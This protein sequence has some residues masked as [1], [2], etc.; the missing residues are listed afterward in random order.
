LGTRASRK[1]VDVT[2][3]LTKGTRNPDWTRDELIIALN[4]YLR[5]RISPPGK[6]SKEVL[7]ASD[8]LNRI[9]TKLHGWGGKEKSFRNANGVYMKLMNFRR[10]DPEYTGTG[11]KGLTAGNKD[12]EVVWN[13]FAARPARCREVARAIVLNLD[14]DDAAAPGNGAELDDLLEEAPEGRLLTRVHLRRERNRGLVESKKRLVLK[15][16]GSLTCEVCAFDFKTEYGELGD[17][18]IECHHTKPLETLQPG[19]KT[20]VRDLALVCSNC[21]RMIHRR[22]PWLTIGELR[23]HVARRDR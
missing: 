7:E 10:F 21:H 14:T 22:R 8:L 18:F 6:G 9:G 23:Q 2:P 5:H 20:H 11:K 3:D 1:G 12:E 17:G 19:S 4:L 16:G 13:Q 15:Q